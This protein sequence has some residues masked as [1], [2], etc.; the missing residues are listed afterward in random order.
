M[1]IRS[2]KTRQRI[3]QCFEQML[4]EKHISKITVT[5]LCEKAKINRATFYKHFL[6]VYHLQELLEQEVLTDLEGFLRDRAFSDNGDYHAMLIELL[7]YA[8]RFGGRFYVLCSA[9]AAS[10]L[11]AKVF[12]LLYSLAFP[13]LQKKL[14]DMEDDQTR[15]LYQYISH[16][17]GSVLRSWLNGESTMTAQEAA[18]FIMMTSGATVAAIADNRRS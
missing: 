16:G 11:P 8:K 18:Q 1:D 17:C 4:A 3:A 15:M 7:T 2:V 14:P 9:N 6:D 12:Q 5:D 13:V 10:D